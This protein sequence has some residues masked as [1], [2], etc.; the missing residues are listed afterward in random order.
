MKFFTVV[1]L[2]LLTSVFEVSY[3]GGKHKFLDTGNTHSSMKKTRGFVHLNIVEVRRDENYIYLKAEISPQRD[4]PSSQLKWQL[5]EG[6][7]V[8]EG[9]EEEISHLKAHKTV[10]S[11]IV[12]EKESLKDNSPLMKPYDRT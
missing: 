9:S 7:K 4:M 3:A 10:F 2:I 6:V 8:A 12:I 1:F 5:P 11:D